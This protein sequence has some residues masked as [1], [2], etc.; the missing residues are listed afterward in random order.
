MKIFLFVY[1]DTVFVETQLLWKQG[2]FEILIFI[3]C[4]EHLNDVCMI[5]SCII[6]DL[7]NMIMGVIMYLLQNKWTT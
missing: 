5:D 6:C 7:K 1:T 3:F 4:A 2:D